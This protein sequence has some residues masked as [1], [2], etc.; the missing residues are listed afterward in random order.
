MEN[1]SRRAAEKMSH[2]ITGMKSPKG[3]SLQECQDSRFPVSLRA[4]ASPREIATAWVRLS[5]PR[6]SHP[7]RNRIAVPIAFGPFTQGNLAI[8]ATLDYG[9]NPVGIHQGRHGRT[10]VRTVSI[11]TAPT[12]LH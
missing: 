8:P 7:G 10:T 6:L 3:K 12:G 5:R 4:S 1:D 11:T 2:S 9:R